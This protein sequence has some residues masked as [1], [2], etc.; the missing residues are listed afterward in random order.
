MKFCMVLLLEASIVLACSFPDIDYDPAIAALIEGVSADSIYH[1]IASLS[2]E[3]PVTIAGE[4]D[5]IPTRYAYSPYS[6]R[7]A[8]WLAERFDSL[9][10]QSELASFIPV[11]FSDADLALQGKG[12]AVARTL[13]GGNIFRTDDGG[14]SWG[15]ADKINRDWVAVETV[16]P[17]TAYAV[18]SRGYIA[19]VVDGE[20]WGAMRMQGAGLFDVS[21]ADSR[22]GWAVGD[23]GII[24]HTTDA[25]ETFTDNRPFP[26]LDTLRYV[27]ASLPQV[28][29]V[30]SSADIWLASHGDDWFLVQHPLETITG[31]EFTDSLSGWL[32]G[33]SSEFRGTVISTSDGGDNWVVLTDTLPHTP[34]AIY[35][36]PSQTLWIAGDA[37]LLAVSHDGGNTWEDHSL[38]YP[39]VINSLSFDGF[40]RGAGSGPEELIYT[41]D[42]TGWSRPDTTGLGLMWNVIA[43]IPGEDLT[44]VLVTAHYDSRSGTNEAYAPGADDNASGVAGVLES[45]RLLSA[46]TPR[47]TLRFVCFG[48]EEFGMFGSYRYVSDATGLRDS[49]LAVMNLDMV[50]YDGNDD[51]V[52]ELNSNIDDPLSVAAAE[53]AEDVVWVYDVNLS[54]RHRV[55]DAKPNSDHGRFWERG[56]TAFM[57]NEDRDDFNPYYHSTNDRLKEMNLGYTTEN[58]RATVG[59]MAHMAK[60]DSLV[61][62]REDVVTPDPIEIH[63]SSNIL[64]S[65]GWLEIS[66]VYPATISIYDASGRMVKNLGAIP[67]SPTL[68]RVSFEVSDLASGV[69]WMRVEGTQASDSR[70]LIVIH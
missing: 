46:C 21:F 17:D 23:S 41:P 3:I 38:D 66:S 26:V 49:I 9:G 13:T 57:L 27:E 35:Y 68:Y 33:L 58:V 63:L 8:Q 47:H 14:A 20:Y 70:K 45:A 39:A 69:Y 67:S 55:A 30:G 2:G 59:W 40:G 48:G 25:W 10:I 5:S 18:S 36:I 31:M 42:G 62:V 50:G 22:T 64:S 1:T 56:F 28:V 43:T 24:L 29:W 61:E 15:Y 11:G 34:R 51:G 32:I 52:V 6:Y 53:V 44:Q 4:P 16:T 37:G 65:R 7:A 54:P 60:I 19:R 12:W